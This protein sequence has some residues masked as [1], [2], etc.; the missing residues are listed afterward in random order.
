MSERR[1]S[2]R[3]NIPSRLQD[4][5]LSGGVAVESGEVNGR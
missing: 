3:R 2:R 5:D 1:S 4:C